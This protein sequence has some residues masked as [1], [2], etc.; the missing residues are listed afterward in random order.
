MVKT[1]FGSSKITRSDLMKDPVYGPLVNALLSWGTIR[2]F[3]SEK[4]T[5]HH[6]VP[7]VAPIIIS[8]FTA[9]STGHMGAGCTLF[10]L[11][12]LDDHDSL[13]NQSDYSHLFSRALIKPCCL[14]VLGDQKGS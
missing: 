4:S 7:G 14:P 6:L 11:I 5:L 13:I 3:G 8:D 2:F 12:H 9:H 1:Q 10:G